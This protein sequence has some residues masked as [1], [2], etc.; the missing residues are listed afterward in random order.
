MRHAIGVGLAIAMVLVLFFAGAW[1]YLRLLRFPA[2]AGSISA[3]PGA[4][5]SLLSNHNVLG[6]M[7]ALI[8]TGLLAGVL[9]GIPRIS[10][11]AAGIPGLILLGWSALYLITVHRAVSIIPLKSHAFGAGFEAMLINGVLAMV[12]TALVVPMFLPSRWMPPAAGRAPEQ[13]DQADL[14]SQWSESEQPRAY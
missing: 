9:I 6:A 8:V 12:G 3:L 4:G 10:P 13:G 5:G 1:G 2:P 7:A 11:L 14:L